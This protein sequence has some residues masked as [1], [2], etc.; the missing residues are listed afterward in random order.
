MAAIAGIASFATG[1]T[2]EPAVF[3]MLRAQRAYGS[4]SCSIDVLSGVTIGSVA[5][6]VSPGDH[7]SPPRGQVL[8]RGD[9]RIDNRR[10]L[11][12]LLQCPG[13]TLETDLVLRAY[14]RWGAAGLGRL[15]GDFAGALY[16]AVD[17]RLILFRDTT[18]QRPLFYAQRGDRILFSSMPSGILAVPGAFVGF[19]RRTLS[20]LLIA[21]PVDAAA[22]SFANIHRVPPGCMVTFDASGEKVTPLW[23]PRFDPLELPRANDYVEQYRALLD[24]AVGDRLRRPGGRVAAHL[25]SGLD[26]SAVAT[27]A[28]RLANA[29]EPMLAVT[30]APRPG[31]SPAWTPR[32]RIADESTLAGIT[33]RRHGMEHLVVRTTKPIVDCLRDQARCY[34]DP[35]RNLINAGW[36][37]S[38]EQAVRERGAT[39]L[40][41]GEMGNH[42]LNAG[43]L[44]VLTDVLRQDGPLAW[45]RE[46]RSVRRHQD[47]RWRGVLF[48]SFEPRL[49]IALQRRLLSL[50]KDVRAASELTFLRPELV[51]DLERGEEAYQRSFDFARDRWRYIGLLDYGTI[52]LGALAE[53]GLD[54]RDPMADRR[55]IEFSLRLPA[56]QVL[57]HGIPR[58]LAR[59][60]LSDRVPNEIL[61][62]RVR[63][64][65]SADWLQQLDRDALGAMVEEIAA[66]RTVDELIDTGRMKRV[67]DRRP[68]RGK[69]SFRDYELFGGHLLQALAVGLFI[70]EFD[71]PLDG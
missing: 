12:S 9:L 36:L 2:D 49:P 18:G 37:A 10:E 3:A 45:W 61:D 51:G 14:A 66:N 68:G 17:R 42:T 67:L 53:N 8:C 54:V 48:N 69:T 32:G 43:G 60:A 70:V 23:E 47:V 56:E 34:Q 29:G 57:N 5:T 46:A 64:V 35:F 33:A 55:L 4:E 11:A 13:N 39:V 19:D 21:V 27:T 30:A 41:S 58:P 65:Q 59:R 63:G 52:R 22:T 50:F 31:F 25:S 20:Q 1:Q 40:L 62:L 44:C 38:C 15:I 26:S 6:S 71:R 7:T 24:E 28:A 16:D